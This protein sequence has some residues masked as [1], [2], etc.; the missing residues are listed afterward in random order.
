[1]TTLGHLSAEKTVGRGYRHPHRA[2]P[3]LK[4]NLRENDPGR[5]LSSQDFGAVWAGSFR[6][7]STLPPTSSGCD[8]NTNKVQTCLNLKN[9][10][11]ISSHSFSISLVPTARDARRNLDRRFR[12]LRRLAEEP[13]P[14]KGWIRAIRDALGMSREE[15]GVRLGVSQQAVAEFEASETRGAIQLDTLKR[16]AEG[17]ECE[18]F[19]FVVPRR[20]LNEMVHDRAMLQ[21]RNHL[22]SVAH[23]SRLED[24]QLETAR[25]LEQLRDV[26]E[27]YIDRRGLWSERSDPK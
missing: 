4:V 6:R 8:L 10:L 18:V 21:A 19:Y 20:D 17:L 12:T 26:A 1:M 2:R 13:R 23:N 24:Q 3:E 5:F 16:V 9:I 25:E 14:H 22:L 15:L 11:L 27:R 7:E